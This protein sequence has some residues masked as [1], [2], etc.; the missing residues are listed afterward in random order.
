LGKEVLQSKKMINSK[1]KKRHYCK[2]NLQNN[3]SDFWEI[4]QIFQLKIYQN[5]GK[6]LIIAGD[7][8]I[9]R[10]KHS[11]E[12]YENIPK[13]QLC[14]MPEKHT[15]QRQTLNYLIVNRFLEKP[16]KRPDSDFTK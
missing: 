1:F 12:M 13:A 2:L 14:I 9:I 11:L 16:F 4:S 8:D 7:E 3:F 5:K 15:H 10:S 6:V